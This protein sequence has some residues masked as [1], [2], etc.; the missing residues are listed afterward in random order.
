MTS[1]EIPKNLAEL[2]GKCLADFKFLTCYS[3]ALIDY[4]TRPFYAR[5][6]ESCAAVICPDKELIEKVWDL[7]PQSPQVRVNKM[8][9]LVNLEKAFGFIPFQRYKK[10]SI[11]LNILTKKEFDKITKKYSEP[12]YW[13]DFKNFKALMFKPGKKIK[14]PF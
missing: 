6:V 1:S 13:T 8:F 11:P 7:L 5:V 14:L 4:E 2:E 9:L 10:E 3:L 12:F